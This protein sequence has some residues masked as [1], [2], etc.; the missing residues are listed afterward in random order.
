MESWDF[1][2]DWNSMQFLIFYSISSQELEVVR[3]P[4]TCGDKHC[5]KIFS[6]PLPSYKLFLWH[7]QAWLEQ[8]TVSDFLT[9]DLTDCQSRSKVSDIQCSDTCLLARCIR[10]PEYSNRCYTGFS[11]SKWAPSPNTAYVSL[12]GWIFTERFLAT[13]IFSTV[14][15]FLHQ[16]LRILFFPFSS[17][18]NAWT[19]R[20]GSF[21]QKPLWK[22]DR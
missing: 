12:A 14:A 18:R 2:N 3:F 7:K 19:L 1:N 10:V 6:V 22:I 15:L 20:L 17:C 5:F 21:S 11:A 8:G 16:A 4:N 9:G 13:L